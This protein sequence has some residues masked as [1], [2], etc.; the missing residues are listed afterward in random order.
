MCENA[1]MNGCVVMF[2]HMGCYGAIKG[3]KKSV[4]NVRNV[5]AFMLLKYK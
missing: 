3:L 1:L 2:Q 5:H 4:R